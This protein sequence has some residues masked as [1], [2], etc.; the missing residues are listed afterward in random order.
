MSEWISVEH[1]IP[2]CGQVIVRFMKPNFGVPTAC[3]EMG[4]FEPPSSGN[5]KSNRCGWLY[6]RDNKPIAWPVTHWKHFEEMGID[7]E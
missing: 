3:Y 6:W 7:G 5:E 2:D 1:E 4:Y